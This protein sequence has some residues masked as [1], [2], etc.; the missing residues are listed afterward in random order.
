MRRKFL[1]FI[2]A[3]SPVSDSVHPNQVRFMFFRFL[4]TKPP[5]TRTFHRNHYLFRE[6]FAAPPPSLSDAP[7]FVSHGCCDKRAHI[8]GLELPTFFTYSSRGWKSHL[9]QGRTD[10]ETPAGEP[11]PCLFQFPE[12]ALIP[13]APQSLPSSLKPARPGSVALVLPYPRF[14]LYF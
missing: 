5:T 10:W 8:R 4:Q 14:L 1:E 6:T 13:P 12:A 2:S 7:V 11:C 9:G 3:E